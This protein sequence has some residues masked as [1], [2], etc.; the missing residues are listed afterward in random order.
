MAAN[1]TPPPTMTWAKAT[2]TLIF[3]VVFDGLRLMFEWFWIFGAVL[4]GLLASG[5]VSQY[6]GS[7][8][9]GNSTGAVIGSLVGIF[10]GPELE[11]FGFIMAFAIGI[12][13]WLSI[14]LWLVFTNSRIFKRNKM[15]LLWIMLGFGASEIPF[16]GSIPA[17]TITMWRMYHTQIK[18]ERILLKKWEDT[19]QKN[20]KTKQMQA[21]LFSQQMYAQQ[22]AEEE[23]DNI[24][25][26]EEIPDE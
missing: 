11:V 18:E 13:G 26:E 9:V 20:I 1:A 23:A 5:V 14:V 2:P 10:G 12:A 22:I 4:S 8:A 16:I 24:Y 17:I 7:S 19:Q 21:A 25:D 3:A 15:S 6:T